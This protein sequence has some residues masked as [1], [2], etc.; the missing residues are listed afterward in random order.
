M[1]LETEDKFQSNEEFRR[2]TTRI[3]LLIVLTWNG[4]A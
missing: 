2:N 3:F 1:G 4:T